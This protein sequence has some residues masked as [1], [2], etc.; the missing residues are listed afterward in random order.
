MKK[1]YFAVCDS[2]EKYC[3]RLTEYLRDNLEFSFDYVSFTDAKIMDEFFDRRDP[4]LVIISEECL[5]QLEELGSID[6][7]QNTIV[8][9]EEMVTED[10]E[11]LGI[12]LDISNNQGRLGKYLPA[13][14]IMDSVIWYCAEYPEQFRDIGL[15]PGTGKSIVHGFYTPLS[16]S[17]QTTLARKVAEGFAR[18]RR[19]VL[20]CLDAY[21]PLNKMF[22]EDPELDITDL[23][24]FDDLNPGKFA[25]NLER[26][27][28]S[29]N[30]LDIIPP[31]KTMKQCREISYLQLMKLIE[32]LSENCG[33]RNIVIDLKDY[34]DDLNDILR[35]C[36]KV[37]T[38]T[39]LNDDDEYRME[40][41]K[42]ILLENGYEDVLN[43]TL[44]CCVPHIKNSE[45][46]DMCVRSLVMGEE[47][48]DPWFGR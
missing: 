24:Y 26:V 4:S 2:N 11:R 13:K 32:H 30:S 21:S 34:S 1:K 38:I 39:R 16:R 14:E 27:K 18:E 29:V 20:I 28:K 37:Y 17:G 31:P 25:L 42:K 8:L 6:K 47:V 35:S 10:P 36:D 45:F 41:Y 9:D 23:L 12:I 48:L 19:T 3:Q 7:Y 5:K 22:G 33:Y 46:Y 15:K 43:K 40:R 44:K